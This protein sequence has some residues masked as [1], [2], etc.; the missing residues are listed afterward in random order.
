MNAF[1]GIGVLAPL[2]LSRADLAS[3]GLAEAISPARITLIG[4]ADFARA[5]Q[6][7]CGVVRVTVFCIQSSLSSAWPA[8][9][10]ISRIEFAPDLTERVHE[11]LLNA[12][13]DG[14]LLPGA[15]ITQEELAASLDVSR[16]PVLQA[17]RLLKKDGFV[18][19]AGRRGLMVSPLDAGMIAG[20]YEVR[21]ALDGLAARRAAQAG[22]KLDP[23]VIAEG[24]KAATGKRV[25]PMIDADIRFHS[26][27]YNASGN[28]HIA[29][30][31]GLHWR[32]IRRAM[33]AVLQYAGVRAAV[34]DEYEA[35]LNAINEGDAARAERLARDH[36]DSAGRN[37]AAQLNQ[38]ARKP[39]GTDSL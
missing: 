30:A 28:A 11:R 38:H 6:P 27:I 4:R 26:L 24:R 2:M 35:I 7:G 20:V 10:S 15:R 18:I 25:G 36:G 3:D 29:E 22:A 16:Q 23:R 5:L 32:H 13:C 37:L 17:L 1:F 31:A 34:W 39:T 8:M 12:I 9:S 14:D 19:D 21:A 33:G